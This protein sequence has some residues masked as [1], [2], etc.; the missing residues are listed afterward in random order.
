MAGTGNL[1]LKRGITTPADGAL[2]RGMPAVQLIAT[3]PVVSNQAYVNYPNRLWMGMD[4][5]Q[6]PNADNCT[7]GTFSWQYAEANSG[8]VGTIPGVNIQCQN[9]GATINNTRPLWMGAEIR[10]AVAVDD[11]SAGNGATILQAD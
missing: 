5:S 2:L 8:T 9:T 4:A 11:A 10:A 6:S 3:S 7:T 1:L